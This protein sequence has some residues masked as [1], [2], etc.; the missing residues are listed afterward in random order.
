MH[1]TWDRLLYSKGVTHSNP[2]NYSDLEAEYHGPGQC[3]D[4]LFSLKINQI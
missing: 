2:E 1:L 3:F 4:L